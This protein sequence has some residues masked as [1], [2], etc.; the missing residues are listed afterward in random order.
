MEDVLEKKPKI[1]DHAQPSFVRTD[2]FLWVD[3]VS[4][5]VSPRR[6]TI[7]TMLRLL[8]HGTAMIVGD[9]ASGKSTILR[10][11]AYQ[12]L[13]RGYIVVFGRARDID[14]NSAL[15]EAKEWN[16]PNTLIVIDDVH[17]NPVACSRLFDSLAALNVKMLFGSRPIAHDLFPEGEGHNLLRLH[18][19]AIR[20]TVTKEVVESITRRFL[21]FCDVQ[22]GVT[23]E[24]I[25]Y[26]YQ[27]FGNDLWLLTYVLL[28]SKAYD[29]RLK[30][31][32][33]H[34]IFQYVYDS[35]LTRW[36]QGSNLL[37]A[38]LKVSAL[39]RYEV[40]CRISY[41]NSLGL[42]EAIRQLVS[43]GEVVAEGEE[44]RIHHSSV[45]RV[46]LETAECYGMI[47]DGL[48]SSDF[49]NRTLV[50]Y[51]EMEGKRSAPLVLYQMMSVPQS[52]EKG[53]YDSLRRA[54]AKVRS[55]ELASYVL[56]E[57]DVEKSG[58]FL[59]SFSYLEPEAAMKLVGVLDRDSL[60]ERLKGTRRR[61]LA[62]F[63][64]TI[65]SINMEYANALRSQIPRI[66][67]VMPAYMEGRGIERVLNNVSDFVD[68]VLVVDDASVDQTYHVAR[69]S[70]AIVHRNTQNMGYSYSLLTGLRLAEA[71]RPD[72]VVTAYGD[73]SL[74]PYFR[75]IPQMAE[76]VFSGKA[77]VV[78]AESLPPRMFGGF[79][80]YS[81]EILSKVAETTI[82]ESTMDPSEYLSGLATDTRVVRIEV[83]SRFYERP[84]ILSLLHAVLSLVRRRTQLKRARIASQKRVRGD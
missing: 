77:D 42:A 79:S 33:R 10:A 53:V 45:A 13:K 56:S 57:T 65:G 16:L 19:E 67:A 80:A 51:I 71:M 17:M 82:N 63:L 29:Y 32:P 11:V 61:S 47:P 3:F 78:I 23:Q 52:F 41:L 59:H 43:R 74:D 39:S 5:V 9:S 37:N 60:L 25:D 46:Y 2:G 54:L 12:M 35:R 7:R 62:S 28:A 81:M 26:V 18:E 76:L 30:D 84:Y 22:D 66:I 8:A 69:R 48:T 15:R 68:K 55:D 73:G 27:G 34:A 50:S 38:I 31:I 20:T 75:L 6:E 49:C 83:P 21:E 70:G 1:A 44:C 36:T 64:S 72:V 14:V 40:P 24:D 4:E 58:Q